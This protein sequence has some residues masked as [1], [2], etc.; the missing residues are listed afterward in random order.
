[1]KKRRGRSKKR[2]NPGRRNKPRL[3]RCYAKRYSKRNAIKSLKSQRVLKTLQSQPTLQIQPDNSL[4]I[5]AVREIAEISNRKLVG[6]ILT[7]LSLNV[8]PYFLYAKEHFSVTAN[9]FVGNAVR[10][11]YTTASSQLPQFIFSTF[12]FTFLASI[13]NLG[14]VALKKEVKRD[15]Q[16]QEQVI[17]LIK[18]KRAEKGFNETDIDVLYNVLKAVGK[19]SFDN[20]AKAFEVQMDIVEEWC[21]ILE[22][23][24]LA[25]INYPAFGCAEIVIKNR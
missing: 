8:I 11:V 17:A 25:A 4:K 16:Q 5:N 20:I 2:G 13:I 9:A 7:A 19:L 22:T 24:N 3:K 14:A 1:M 18:Q 12:I 23:N 6:L 21:K 10:T 15:K